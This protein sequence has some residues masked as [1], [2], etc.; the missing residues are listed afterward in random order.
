M[1][2]FRTLPI[3][4]KLT[5]IIFLVSMAVLAPTAL[6][7][8]GAQLRFLNQENERDLRALAVAV[9][10]QLALFLTPMVLVAKQWHLLW[11][12]ALLLAVL[13]VLLYF[14]WYRHLSTDPPEAVRLRDR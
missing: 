6:L 12:L 5:G 8:A 4:Q 1:N 2:W 13:S 3:R 11:P 9:P 14:T 10:W 7:V